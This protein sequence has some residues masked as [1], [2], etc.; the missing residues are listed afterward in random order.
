MSTWSSVELGKLERARETAQDVMKVDPSFSLG[1]A[2]KFLTF[3]DPSV[4][5][6]ILSSLAKAGLPE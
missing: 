6:R 3:K 5:D 2:A 1:R 4:T